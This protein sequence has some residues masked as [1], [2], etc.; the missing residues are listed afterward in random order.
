M[1]YFVEFCVAVCLIVGMVLFGFFCLSKVVAA[2]LA[3][4][5]AALFLRFEAAKGLALVGAG[6]LLAAAV[7]TGLSAIL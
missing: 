2:I 6:F 5:L 7:T 4:S 3:V 1:F